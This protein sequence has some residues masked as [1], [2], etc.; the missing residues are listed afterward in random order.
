MK[1][2]LVD[3]TGFDDISLHFFA[4]ALLFALFRGLLRTPRGFAMAAAVSAAAVNELID[5]L[6][7]ISRLHL[8]GEDLIWTVFGAGFALITSM[9]LPRLGRDSRQR[10][11]SDRL[12]RVLAGG[13]SQRDFPPLRRAR[14][15]RTQ[16]VTA[17]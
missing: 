5:A 13:P 6:H 10:R 14:A 17:G 8:I 1:R 15:G 3:W 9:L 2:W 16:R 7:A 12:K 11:R 4:G